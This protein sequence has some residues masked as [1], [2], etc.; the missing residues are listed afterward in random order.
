MGSLP[1]AREKNST[2][3]GRKRKRKLNDRTKRQSIC[4]NII[5]VLS[6]CLQITPSLMKQINDI[7]PALL[8]NCIYTSKYWS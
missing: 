5:F 4:S 3:K 6:L 8:S 1:P 2:K 7:W